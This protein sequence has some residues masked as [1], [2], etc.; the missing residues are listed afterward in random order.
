MRPVDKGVDQGEFNPHNDAQQ[1]LM[2]Q[3][4][5]YCSYCER[6]IASGIHVEHKKPKKEYPQDQ[7]RWRN[8]LLS[9]CNCNS[10]KGHGELDLLDYVWPDCD[11][12]FRAF[13]YDSEGRV[14]PQSGYGNDLDTKLKKTWLMLGLDRHP[15]VRTPGI[16]MPTVKD[17]RWIHR[18]EA[19]IKALRYRNK[20]ALC[21]TSEL[22]ADIVEMATERG[23]FSI[24]MSVFHDDSNLRRRL[25]EAFPGTA[26][27]CFDSVGQPVQRPGGQL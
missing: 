1:P 2:E 5:E 13:L 10:G 22:R 19:W 21:D 26:T 11:N 18:R 17:K 8:F 16:Q 14:L 6:W 20:L 3:L 15:D 4:G 25:I 27:D 9:C 23:M 12:T 24:W 7:Y